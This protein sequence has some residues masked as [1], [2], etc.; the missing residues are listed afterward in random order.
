MNPENVE[1]AIPE[2]IMAVHSP[3]H[4]EETSEISQKNNKSKMKRV[5]THA[6]LKNQKILAH[7]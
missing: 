7:L 5:V 2:N 6:R 4:I 3:E 1:M